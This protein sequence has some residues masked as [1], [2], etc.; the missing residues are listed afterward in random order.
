MEFWQL[1]SKRIDSYM[2]NKMGL[3]QDEAARLRSRYLEAQGTTLKGLM[4]DFDI[5]PSDYLAYVHQLDYPRL[6]Q[7]DPE[8]RKSLESL[9]Q[10]KYIFTNASA[11]HAYHVLD[12][13]G[14][15]DQ[16]RGVIDV[17][18]MGYANKPDEIAYI[19]ALELIGSPDP[20][21][22]LM[23]DDRLQ[24]LLPAHAMGMTTVLVG[25]KTPGEADIHLDRL[26][27]LPSAMPSLL[28]GFRAEG[29]PHG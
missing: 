20:E 18:A 5:D 17:V 7:P 13:L 21:T 23:A 27:E 1:I 19:R 28:D 8:L 26:A 15:T 14:L 11:A 2:T 6:I 10:T 24:N 12:A 22:C 3:S 25:P 29:A 4:R 16:F 9:P